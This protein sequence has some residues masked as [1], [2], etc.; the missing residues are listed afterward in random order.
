VCI[1]GSDSCV[2]LQ[3]S[4]LSGTGAGGDAAPFTCSREPS[5]IV[6]LQLQTFHMHTYIPSVT[7]HIYCTQTH[8]RSDTTSN[9]FPTTGFKRYPLKGPIFVLPPKCK[10]AT[11]SSQCIL[12]QSLVWHMGQWGWAGLYVTILL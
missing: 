10:F 12:V 3:Q 4:S 5:A 11:I 8:R 2:A 6:M 7:Q 9:P 1:R